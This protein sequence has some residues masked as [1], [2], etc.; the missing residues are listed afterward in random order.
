[1][2]GNTSVA[3]VLGV[4]PVMS[5]TLSCSGEVE[6]AS[7]GTPGFFSSLVVGPIL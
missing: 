6:E 7:N 5:R 3:A 1:M 4:P 2:L